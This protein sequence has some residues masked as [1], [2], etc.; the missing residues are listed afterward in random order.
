MCNYAVE[1]YIFVAYAD[2]IYY[3]EKNLLKR[4]E[5]IYGNIGNMVIFIFN[6]RD[7]YFFDCTYYT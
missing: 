5:V 6:D 2:Y 4:E 3:N 7:H 1:Y